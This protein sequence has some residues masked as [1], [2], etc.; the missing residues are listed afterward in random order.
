MEIPELPPAVQG[1]GIENDVVMNVDP[2]GMRSND[3][4]VPA[5]GKCQCQF[6]ADTVCFLG[7]DLSGLKDCRIWY[8]IT[9]PL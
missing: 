8:A 9:F 1:S 7:G 3:E 2:V 5:F 4:G 6:I